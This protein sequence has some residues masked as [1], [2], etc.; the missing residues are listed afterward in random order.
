ML[1]L[2]NYK[3]DLQKNYKEKKMKNIAQKIKKDWKFFSILAEAV[4]LIWMLVC[5]LL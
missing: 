1:Y 4:I 2:I 3:K 5:S